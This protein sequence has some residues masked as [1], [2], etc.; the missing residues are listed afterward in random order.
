MAQIS[1]EACDFDDDGV[2]L[3]FVYLKESCT[4]LAQSK[5]VKQVEE[6]LQIAIKRL[7]QLYPPGK[8]IDNKEV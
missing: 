2:Y 7:V 4:K 8:G 1:R 3:L 5:S 6:L